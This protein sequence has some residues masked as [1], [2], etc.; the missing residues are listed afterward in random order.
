MEKLLLPATFKIE[1]TGQPNEARI[2]VEPCY[3]G[4]GTTL[5]NALRRVLLSS[6]P[7]AAVTAVKIK[8]APHEF[9]TIENVKEDGV[10][11]ILNL[12]KLRL[13]VFSPEPVR[14]LLEAK[15]EGE[16]TA[17]QIQVTSDV[18]IVN[19][20]LCL[21]TL[22]HKNAK[23][24]MEI[25]VSQGR[26]YV[27]VEEKDQKKWELGTIAVDSIFTPVLN[28]GYKVE[29]VRVGEITDFEKLVLTI[30]T[31]GT[32]QPAN[33]LLQATEI[34]LDHFNLIL[35]GFGGKVEMKREI[36]TAEE[37]TAEVLTAGEA[38]KEE[39]VVEEMKEKKEPAKRGRKKGSTVK[40]K[41]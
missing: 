38:A 6:L 1:E 20:D 36:E 31:D 24:E 30:E 8:G 25:F 10:E 2:V 11:I 14:L 4:Y 21:A 26:G 39:M 3:H 32:I 23:L 35:E 34:L 37:E 33:A 27:P 29:F 28:V 17:A 19:P 16:V 22:T 18:E 5:G 12:K 15:G 41:K 7:G 13:R 40:K 9:T